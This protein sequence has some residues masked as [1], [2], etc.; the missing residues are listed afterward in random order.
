VYEAEETTLTDARVES[1]HP[2][3]T[4]SGFVNYLANSGAGIRWTNVDVPS[5]GNYTLTFRYALGNTDRPVEIKV[6]GSIVESSLNFP[7]T[8]G[9]SNWR[10]LD[11]TT[12]L[13]SGTNTIEAVTIGYDGP[14]I[15]HLVYRSEG[16]SVQTQIFLPY[17]SKSSLP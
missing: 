7:T 3:Y 2:G 10:T 6:N 11:V 12:S 14:N 9:W 15:D 13:N 16:S 5:S 8:G 4:G 17:V 1:N